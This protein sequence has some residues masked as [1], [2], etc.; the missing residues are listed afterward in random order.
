M[1]MFTDLASTF[2]QGFAKGAQGPV[3]LD[4]IASLCGEL[5]W[6]LDERDHRSITLHFTHPSL[7]LCKVVVL[8]DSEHHIMSVFAMSRHVLEPSQ[9]NPAMLA[10]L[11]AR[12][13]E[14]LWGAWQMCLDGGL[15]YFTEKYTGM[16]QGVEAKAFEVMCNSILKEVATFDLKMN[17]LV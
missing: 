16:M 5:G 12:N 2:A 6:S 4:K 15:A 9:V 13:G 8:A 7:G 1:G 14:T 3:G 17:E 11:L 10:L